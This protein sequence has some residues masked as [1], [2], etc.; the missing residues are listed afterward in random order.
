V[1][2]KQPFSAPDASGGRAADVDLDDGVVEAVRMVL[3]G[4]ARAESRIACGK[5]LIAQMLCGSNSAKVKKLRLN[6]LS[7]FGLLWQLKQAEVVTLIEVLMAIGCLEQEDIDR[8]RPVLKLTPLGNDVMRGKAELPAGLKLPNELWLKLRRPV[9]KKDAVAKGTER[10]AQH[11]AMASGVD[12]RRAEVEASQSQ[13]GTR[14]IEPGPQFAE[15]PQPEAD[16]DGPPSYDS[17]I[18]GSIDQ[19]DLVESYEP[20]GQSAS[21]FATAPV[22]DL[23]GE[24]PAAL[25][26]PS[27]SNAPAMSRPPHYW[28]W[29]L[30][31]RG[32]EAEECLA[33]R[34]ITRETLL[35][36]VLQA[37][38]NG[39]E[40]RLD[41][42]LS[43]EMIAA[44]DEVIG[45]KRPQQIRPLLA[46][47]PPGTRYEEVQLYV[48]CSKSRMDE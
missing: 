34:A 15:S 35:D 42:C 6:Q 41:W 38:E 29:L 12:N 7:T 4:V 39:L 30:L 9:A 28:T 46:Q 1:S 14:N 36:H 37:A 44:L 27:T 26:R 5:N 13:A 16:Y 43:P 21:D 19:E 20:V 45:D 22:I 18:I 3:S 10:S 33:I 48:K 32:F 8:F 23:P 25:A 24:S 2:A 40:V 11:D 31:S 17:W 47:L